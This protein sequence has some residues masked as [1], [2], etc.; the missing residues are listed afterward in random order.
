MKRFSRIVIGRAL[1]FRASGDTSPMMRALR[2]MLVAALMLAGCREK[3]REASRGSPRQIRV[4][5]DYLPN[6]VHVGICQAEAAGYFRD[7][8]LNV[9]IDAPTSSSTRSA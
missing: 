1:A 9:R 4:I 6:T 5:L 8:G 7:E 2:L 3:A